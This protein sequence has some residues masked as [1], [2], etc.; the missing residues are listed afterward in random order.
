MMVAMH[1]FYIVQ[2][3]TRILC[4]PGSVTLHINDFMYQYETQSERNVD[5]FVP[6]LVMTIISIPRSIRCRAVAALLHHGNRLFSAPEHHWPVQH[7][8]LR[9]LAP[10]QQQ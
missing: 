6:A 3:H 9:A 5:L 7:W 4:W 8:R 10:Q 2:V 1:R